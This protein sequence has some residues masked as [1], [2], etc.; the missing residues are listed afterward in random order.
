MVV[1]FRRILGSGA[2]KFHQPFSGRI[3]SALLKKVSGSFYHPTFSA[4]ATAIH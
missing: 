1:C 3:P 2:Q 4:T